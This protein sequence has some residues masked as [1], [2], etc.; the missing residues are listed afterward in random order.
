MGCIFFFSIPFFLCEA[1]SYNNL[2]LKTENG[3]FSTSAGVF[4][5]A[6]ERT[7]PALLKL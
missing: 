3:C 1:I 6:N 2:I 7:G 4:G 5:P